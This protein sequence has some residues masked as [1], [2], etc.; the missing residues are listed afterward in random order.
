MC[1]R[2]FVLLRNRTCAHEP[3]EHSTKRASP[4][5]PRSGLAPSSGHRGR[6]LSAKAA[7]NPEISADFEQVFVRIIHQ[8]N[9]E[10]VLPVINRASRASRGRTP[11]K[12]SARPLRL[13]CAGAGVTVPAALQLPASEPVLQSGSLSKPLRAQFSDSVPR[14]G[15]VWFITGGANS[16][17]RAWL[18]LHLYNV[19][20]GP[21]IQ[22]MYPNILHVIGL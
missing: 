20:H 19:T 14:S 22:Y 7:L 3:S 6:E 18:A 8:I 17:A 9:D 10:Q 11:A 1:K 4:R 16:T 12:S 21:N 5:P 15:L 2:A 13:P